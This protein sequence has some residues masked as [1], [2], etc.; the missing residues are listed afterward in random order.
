MAKYTN[1]QKLMLFEQATRENIQ[2]TET[3]T[4]A[5]NTKKTIV[6]PKSRTLQKISLLCKGTFKLSH[7]IKTTYTAKTFNKYHLL[8]NLRL[9]LNNGFSPYDLSGVGLYM[10][11]QQSQYKAIT[12]SQNTL[13]YITN[14]VSSTG[15]DNSVYFML[16]I[17][18]TVNDRDFIGL[19]DM[20]ASAINVEFEVT[21]GNIT[22]IMTDTDITASSISITCIPVLTTFSIPALTKDA[23]PTF[24]TVKIV[25]EQ[26]TNISSTGYTTIKLPTGL[27]Y[28]K[29]LLYLKQD[30]NYTPIPLSRVDS[31][32]LA[33]NQADTPYNIPADYLVNRNTKQ[34]GASFDTGLYSFDFSNN[35]IANYGS[36]RDY[37]DSENLSEFWVKVNMATLSGS[38]NEIITIS[39]QIAQI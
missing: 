23:I 9:K 6:L 39:E 29:L 8:R 10:Y 35:G 12:D 28:R 3:I 30:A 34:R 15:A 5:E 25:H 16:D 36:G 22:D 27:T 11:N 4:F 38:V 33:L 37:M 14:V 1:M 32:S 17:P 19:L 13:D 7:A 2:T 31:F 18:I 26:K 24:D 21:F 20:Q